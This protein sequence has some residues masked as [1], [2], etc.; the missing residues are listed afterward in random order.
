MN[1]LRA[2]EQSFLLTPFPDDPTG[3]PPLFPDGECAHRTYINSG[4]NND[5]RQEFEVKLRHFDPVQ[6][7]PF[8]T[9]EML[10]RRRGTDISFQL[11]QLSV[12]RVLYDSQTPLPFTGHLILKELKRSVQLGAPLQIVRALCSTSAGM[13]QGYLSEVVQLIDVR[14]GQP[15][16]EL[17][18]RLIPG[19]SATL[20]QVLNVLCLCRERLIYNNFMQMELDQFLIPLLNAGSRTILYSTFPVGK[21]NFAVTL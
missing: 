2:R 13:P 4:S 8:L 10:I 9:W 5:P 11:G 14:H 15:L 17:G 6:D 12:D 18:R 3:L 19:P 20:M 1:L 21:V 16:L 7:D